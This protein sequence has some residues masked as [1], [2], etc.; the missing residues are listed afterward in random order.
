MPAINLASPYAMKAATLTV[1]G[2]DFTAAVS[3]AEFQP[4][5]SSGTFVSIG[6]TTVTET[7]TA[8]WTLALGLAQDDN[9]AGLLRY[10]YDNEGKAVV[11]TLRPRATGGTLWTATVIVSPASVGGTAGNAPVTSQVNLAVVGKPA[12]SVAA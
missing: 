10:L 3:Q 8:T 11:V 12:P 7:A 9:P 1:A 6:G 2:S 4:S 5:V